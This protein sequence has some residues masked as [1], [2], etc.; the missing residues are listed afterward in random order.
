MPADAQEFAKTVV[1][2]ATFSSPPILGLICTFWFLT[3]TRRLKL[4]LHQS[5]TELP[6]TRLEAVSIFHRLDSTTL[7]KEHNFMSQE[8]YVS[9]YSRVGAPVKSLAIILLDSDNNLKCDDNQFL[10]AG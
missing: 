1:V 10:A 4:S 9:L 5:N 7:M 6:S 2:S 3:W 8:V